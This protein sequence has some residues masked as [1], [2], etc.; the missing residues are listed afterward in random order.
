MHLRRKVVGLVRNRI[1]KIIGGILGVA[2][3]AAMVFVAVDPGS[4]P[5]KQGTTAPVE[6][7]VPVT[8]P[9]P[10][11]VPVASAP[12]GSVLLS[13]VGD[14]TLAS[15]LG[16]VKEPNLLWMAQNKPHEYFFEGV[17]DV[18]SKD[19]LTFANCENVFTDRYLSKRPK[20]GT[21]F[22]FTSPASNADIL[23]LG[24]VEVAGVANNH[25]YDYREDGLLDTV[26]ALEAQGIVAGQD[27][28]PVY[29][30]AKDM[31]IGVVFCT[32]WSSG[33]R[34]A[35]ENALTNMQDNCDYSI[36]YFHGGSEGRH[37]PDNYVIDVCRG[38]ANSGLC[39]LIVGSHS[40]VLQPMEVVN[41]VPIAYS[42][43]NF[44]FGGNAHPENMTAI[45]QVVLTETDGGITTETSFVPCYVHT[46]SR[47]NYQPAL[48]TDS[49]DKAE[50]MALLTAKVEKRAE[51]PKASSST[52]PTE[53]TAA[54]Q[55][56]TQVPV[57]TDPVATDPPQQET[58]LS[59]LPVQDQVTEE[60]DDGYN[61]W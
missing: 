14:C 21:A 36:V 6:E 7:T 4:V 42:L 12:P 58:T 51:E 30:Q 16:E 20:S 33:Q 22:W 19:D 48:M 50:V 49:A 44:C 13:F 40:H 10:G 3:A 59:D 56:S 27:C 61:Y 47:N 57:V 53:S 25:T 26:S 2:V 17:Y 1:N 18:L 60:N 35:I 15:D 9:L 5:E 29:V 39:D 28:V 8:A 23:K 34:T 54:T 55:P 31:T 11:D 46:G 43:G 41:N 52:A 45:M 37:Y 38:L 32:M 24:S